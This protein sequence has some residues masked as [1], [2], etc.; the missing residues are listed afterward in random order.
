MHPRPGQPGYGEGEASTG[1]V[2]TDSSSSYIIEIATRLR[3]PASARTWVLSAAAQQLNGR[4][5]SP[6]QRAQLI[7]GSSCAHPY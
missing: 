5:L 4:A 7:H 6:Q 1:T 3:H 2:T